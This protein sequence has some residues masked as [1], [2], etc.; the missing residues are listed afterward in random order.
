MSDANDSAERRAR[1]RIAAK[2]DGETCVWVEIAGVRHPVI[3]LSME[4]FSIPVTEGAEMNGSFDVVL[5]FN[6]IP[7]RI[8]GQA[9][10]VNRVDSL[11]GP[12]LG[13]RFLSLE[14]DGGDKL[15]E[16][17]TVIV[18]CG[19]SVRISVKDAQSIVSGPSMI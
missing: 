3:D 9:E 17:L 4:G 10:K 13:C 15:Y 14:G 18:I 11:E 1:Q 8:R 6:D 2:R 5:R 16:W 7:D 12:R 19:A